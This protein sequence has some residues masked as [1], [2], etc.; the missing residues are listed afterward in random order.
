MSIPV[1][2]QSPGGEIHYCRDNSKD[3][4][5][6]NDNSNYINSGILIITFNSEINNYARIVRIICICDIFK[7][8]IFFINSGGQNIYYIGC[9]LI[10]ISGYISTYNNNRYGIIIYITYNYVNL[11]INL[12]NILTVGIVTSNI[13]TNNITSDNNNRLEI[14][15][16]GEELILFID[17][18]FRFIIILILLKY[19]NIIVNN[20][21]N[22]NIL[23]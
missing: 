2:I 14:I 6:K 1:A 11:F 22:N 7:N 16:Y 17:F 3:N 15:Y 23:Y 8:Y 19:Y 20:N 13:I 5:E 12:I 18:L 10:S 21:N 9:T 4:S